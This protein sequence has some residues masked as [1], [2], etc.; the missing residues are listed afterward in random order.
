MAVTLTYDSVLSRVQIAATGLG[1]ATTAVVE[2]SLDQITWVT[3]RGGSAVP[4]AGGS[5]SQ[6]VDDYEFEPNALNYYRVRTTGAVVTF[7]NT[8]TAA[9]ADNAAVS[10]ALPAGAAAGDVLLIFAAR[11]GSGDTTA[12]AGY[13]LI[14]TYTLFKLYGKIHSGAEA[15]PTVGITGGAAGDT[16]G[17]QMAAFRDASLTVVGG[18]VSQTNG[19]SSLN[20][21]HPAILP[22]APKALVLAFGYKLTAW[23]SV[24]PLPDMTEVGDTSST[25]G[26]DHGMVWDF[27]VQ[28]GDPTT[29]NAGTFVTTGA[30]GS[31]SRSGML[32]LL[33]ASATSQTNSITPTLTT[34]W[35]KSVGRPFLN[36]PI[37]LGRISPIR[38]A[39]RHGVFPIIDRS[40]PIAIT[41]VRAGL[42]VTVQVITTT[43]EARQELDLLLAAGDQVLVQSPPGGKLP[44]NLHAVIGD[45]SED[46]FNFVS[47]CID[48]RAFELPL[49]QVAPPDSTIVPATATWQTVINR[50]TTWADVLAAHSTW[51][52]VLAMVADPSEVIVP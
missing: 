10:P 24:A 8:G 39:A 7:V 52:S 21:N 9:H 11:R 27:V 3:V 30:S 15:A 34:S 31:S 4:A 14:A 50:Y 17:A 43:T 38:R 48:P 20:I 2:R 5:M 35:L 18:P 23:T 49:Q 51:A 28:P 41:Q 22:S 26:N 44:T 32:A 12:P 29:V 37:V 45:T 19:T 6:T 46:H 13:S 25:L 16:T 33:P 36:R 42:A 47:D 40:M 1:G